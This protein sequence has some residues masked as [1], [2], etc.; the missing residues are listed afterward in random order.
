LR[1][2]ASESPE[3][4]ICAVPARGPV[5]FVFPD[6]PLE[7]ALRLMADWPFLAVASRVNSRSLVGIISMDD[8]LRV[9]RNR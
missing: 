7:E 8:I 3:T 1:R 2:A 9:Y 4:L 5:P 6:Q